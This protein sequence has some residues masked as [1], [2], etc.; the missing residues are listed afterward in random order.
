MGEPLKST[1]IPAKAEDTSPKII[2]LVGATAELIADLQTELKATK[3]NWQIE[4]A[5]DQ[6]QALSRVG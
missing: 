6:K 3:P 5:S 2:L 4:V 1:E